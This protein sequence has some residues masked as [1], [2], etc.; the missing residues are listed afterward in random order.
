MK[1]A[2]VVAGTA[3][4]GAV[5]L[6]L[7]APVGLF[8]REHVSPTARPYDLSSVP[9]Q[10]GR[11]QTYLRQRPSDARVWAELGSD[12]VEQ[13]RLSGDPVYYAK[14]GGALRRSLSLDPHRNTD[15]FIGMGAL[16]VA[17]HR[18]AAGERLARTAQ[19]LD[20]HRWSA[21]GVLGDAAIELG[22][23]RGAERLLERMLQLRPGVASFT[24][25]AHL[26]ELKGDTR[27]AFDALHR[28]AHTAATPQDVSYCHFRLGELSWNTGRTAQALDEYGRALNATPGNPY[29]LAG[30]AR[31]EAAVGRTDE[32]VADYTKAT[33]RLPSPQFLLELGELQLARHQPQEAARQFELLAAQERILHAKGVVDDLTIGRYEADHGDPRSAVRHL[34]AEW[35]RRQTVDVADALAWALHRAGKDRD[36]LVRAR[37]SMRLGG[38]TAPQ[39]FHL[40]EIERSLRMRAAAARHLRQALAINPAFSPLYADQARQDLSGSGSS[41]R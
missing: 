7:L 9:V 25:A 4:T 39:V 22:D 2:L 17:Q 29:A 34:K 10:I 21:Y 40:G 3:A 19:R 32:A 41:A 23:Y 1:K 31:A 33:S 28:A 20:P 5:G 13:A 6:A 35:D 30:Q 11:A 24:R 38:R 36:A 26:L 12:Y 14:A 37:W 16:A 18:F 8:A 15:A 27:K